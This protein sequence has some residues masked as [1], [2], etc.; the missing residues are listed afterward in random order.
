MN[1]FI[2]RLS[3]LLSSPLSPQGQETDTLIFQMT[4]TRW[5]AMVGWGGEKG[6]EKK[7]RGPWHKPRVR[8][9]ERVRHEL[10]VAVGWGILERHGWKRKIERD[11]VRGE[12][13]VVEGL[14]AKLESYV[15]V[16]KAQE[17]QR[18]AVNGSSPCLNRLW[19]VAQ[20]AANHQS[21]WRLLWVWALTRCL[22]P[23]QGDDGEGGEWRRQEEGEKDKEMRR[24][25]GVIQE[26]EKRTPTL[27]FPFFSVCGLESPCNGV[28]E[29]IY[30]KGPV[31]CFICLPVNRLSCLDPTCGL[32][33]TTIRRKY[34]L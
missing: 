30:I 15:T 2:L 29:W 16:S 1:I 19:T 4:H 11:K 10:W 9:R 27:W 5:V 3:V 20:S 24:E 18:K 33:Y 8:E 26:R 32:F 21:S 22:P 14:R 31:F 6:K 17:Q 23:D 7:K 34:D 12:R 13:A 28:L 25:G